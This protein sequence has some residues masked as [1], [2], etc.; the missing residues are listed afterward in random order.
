MVEDTFRFSGGA[1][2]F[3][4]HAAAVEPQDPYVAL[5]PALAHNPMSQCKMSA[6]HE[7]TAD[8]LRRLAVWATRQ[9]ERLEGC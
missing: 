1:L 4:G 9:A 3:F 2:L 8:D 6:A 5:V 7:V